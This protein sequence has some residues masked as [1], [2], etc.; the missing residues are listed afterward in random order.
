MVQAPMTFPELIEAYIQSLAAKASYSRTV[1]VCRPW[2]LTLADP[3]TRAQ[4]LARQEAIC[5]AGKG[6]NATKANKELTVL[7][8]AI[9]RGIY[10]GTWTAGD[11]T[12]GIKKCKTRIRERVAYHLELKALL[13]SFA[14]P[15]DQ[16]GLRDRAPF[17]A[18]LM[19]G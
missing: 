14:M 12:V 3:P 8:A 2:L 6:P 4:I 15:K 5:P 1:R 7:R 19:S 18:A 11:P 13:E 17:G 16:A 9:R 10:H